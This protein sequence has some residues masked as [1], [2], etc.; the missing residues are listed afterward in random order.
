MEVAT[1]ALADGVDTV[2]LAGLELFACLEPPDLNARLLQCLKDAD[3]VLEG[4]ERHDVKTSQQPVSFKRPVQNGTPADNE[5]LH[6]LAEGTMGGQNGDLL[7]GEVS[8]LR[9]P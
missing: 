9:N 6:V 3:L 2:R 4:R 5:C 7:L 1:A 8:R